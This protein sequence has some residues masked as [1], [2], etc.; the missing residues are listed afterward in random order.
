MP[1]T[2]LV[3]LTDR[4]SEA[5]NEYLKASLV[6]NPTSCPPPPI[7]TPNTIILPFIS[8]AVNVWF[9]CG[10][11][12]IIRRR[13]I[14]FCFVDS[15][16]IYIQFGEL[17][18]LSASGFHFGLFID[19]G[20]AREYVYD[21]DWISSDLSLQRIMTFSLQF[22]KQ[23]DDGL[24]DITYAARTMEYKSNVGRH[25]ELRR[26]A[27]DRGRACSFWGEKWEGQEGERV[28]F[29]FQNLLEHQRGKTRWCACVSFL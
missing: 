7:S 29:F 23:I 17:L 13:R 19:Q 27:T 11:M 6:T 4:L 22:G 12:A 16:F 21:F 26:E 1:R 9:R 8:N 10:E 14:W 18:L 3:R 25:G 2:S 5:F 20:E 15:L 28:R 24:P